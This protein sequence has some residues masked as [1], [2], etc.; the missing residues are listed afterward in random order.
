L[1]KGS[2][3]NRSHLALPEKVEQSVCFLFAKGTKIILFDWNLMQKGICRQTSM[4]EFEMENTKFGTTF[5]NF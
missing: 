5:H 2:P 1:E 4:E 3:E